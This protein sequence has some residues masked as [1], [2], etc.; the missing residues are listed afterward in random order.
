MMRE[1]SADGHTQN[2][3]HQYVTKQR[4]GRNGRTNSMTNNPSVIH[5]VV[6]DE[7][8]QL[9]WLSFKPTIVVDNSDYFNKIDMDDGRQKALRLY[10]KKK[11][12]RLSTLK[13]LL[14]QNSK[15]DSRRQNVTI[16]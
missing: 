14:L 9:K 16:S 12:F 7:I 2:T 3:N 4:V 11:H 13:D 6:G 1:N 15:L 5:E 8:K 10:S